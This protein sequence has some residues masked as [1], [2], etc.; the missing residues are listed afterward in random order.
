[1]SKGIIYFIQ[2]SELVGTNRYKIG[3]SKFPDL[4]RCKNGYRMGS[5]YI[6]IMECN[7]PLVL[8]KNIKDEF[9][10]LFKLISGYEYFE[11]NEYIMKKTFLKIFEEYEKLDNDFI[12]DQTT[13]KK[14]NNDFILNQTTY[15]KKY[16]YNYDY[17]EVDNIIFSISQATTEEKF[18]IKN[19]L[20]RLYLG[21]D[22]VN[23]EL[24]DNYDLSIIIKYLGLI[25]IENIIKT[26]DN[27]NEYKEEVKRVEIVQKLINDLGFKNMYDRETIIKKDEFL[28][29]IQ[30]LDSFNDDKGLRILFNCRSIQKNFDSIKS[31]LGCV[32]SMLL[33]YSLKVQS[34]RKKEDN[35]ETYNYTLDKIKERIYIDELLQY[36]IN[37]G[38]TIKCSIRN[39]KQIEYSEDK[40]KQHVVGP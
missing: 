40:E 18:K 6:I 32:N 39:Y 11:G 33:H 14:L 25:N 4:E 13:Y 31:F 27:D 30:K 3:C 5:R 12:L 34:N 8:E 16:K 38:L 26:N 2:P 28:S 36:R 37:K 35:K 22:E 10:K 29:R 23:Q 1:M 15:E 17:C 7:N 24:I 20:F 9:N 21:I 19:C